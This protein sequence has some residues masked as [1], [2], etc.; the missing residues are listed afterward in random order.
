MLGSQ[1]CILRVHWHNLKYTNHF[2]KSKIFLT[3]HD[4]ELKKFGHLL[5][6]FRRW[7]QNCSLGVHGT[8]FQLFE[9]LVFF[10]SPSDVRREKFRLYVGKFSSGLPKLL[11]MF[12]RN[13]SKK[14][15]FPQKSMSLFNSFKKSANPLASRQTNLDRTV[16]TAFWLSIG[17]FWGK[18]FLRKISVLFITL[19]LRAKIF[20]FFVG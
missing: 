12:H 18:R 4:F 20:E 14:S 8:I 13:N 1:S 6:L 19:G 3:F 15:A 10:I 16:K 11:S 2:A 5:K 9:K 7:C 17:P